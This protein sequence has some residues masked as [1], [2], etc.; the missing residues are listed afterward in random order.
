MQVMVVYFAAVVTLGLKA[1]ATA[2]MVAT[3]AVAV[4]HDPTKHD[5]AVMAVTVSSIGANYN[6]CRKEMGYKRC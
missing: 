1:K 4:D 5:Q 2:A 3:A 6:G